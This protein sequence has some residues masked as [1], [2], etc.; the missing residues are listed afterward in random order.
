MIVVS[1][2]PGL[3]GACAVLGHNG[4]RAVF[5]LPTM[6]IPNI[7]PKA[8]VQNKIDGRALCSLLLQHC[9]AAEGTPTVVIEAV[10][11]MGGANNAVQTQGSLLR[12]LG[13]IETVA[14]CLKFPVVYANPQT[15]KRWYGL[16]QNG[17]L[18]E[19]TASQRTA[20]AKRKAMD[21]ARALFPG[22]AEISRAK[23]HNRAESILLGHWWRR[24]H[25][26]QGADALEAA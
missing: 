16:I 25:V 8:M 21:T 23:D 9:P 19:L 13:A 1:I 2:D 6:K 18:T 22:C 5:D 17:A 11:T 15:W 12:S 14:E 24:N 26:E 20:A 10:G 4:L 7:G 3:T